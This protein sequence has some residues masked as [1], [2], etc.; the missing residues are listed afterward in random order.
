MLSRRADEDWSLPSR[1]TR[2]DGFQAL[3]DQRV[4]KARIACGG[5]FSDSQGAFKEI[6]AGPPVHPTA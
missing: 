6:P 3:E 5:S 2:K 1:H 4:G